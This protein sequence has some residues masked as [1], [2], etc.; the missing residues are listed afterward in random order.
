MKDIVLIALIVL[1]LG[2]LVELFVPG[3]TFTHVVMFA[4]FCVSLVIAD[5]LIKVVRALL[6]GTGE[7][8]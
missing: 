7:G 8:Q 2:I 4:G 6:G 3:F 1:M 5:I